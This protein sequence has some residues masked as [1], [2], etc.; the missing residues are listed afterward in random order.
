MHKPIEHQACRKHSLNGGI[1]L[2]PH[3]SLN[4]LRDSLA[5]SLHHLHPA[6]HSRYT[7][8]DPKVSGAECSEIHEQLYP[9]L[10]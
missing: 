8:Q 7:F 2:W 5:L 10:P 3:N 4:W 6:E 9:S 1:V